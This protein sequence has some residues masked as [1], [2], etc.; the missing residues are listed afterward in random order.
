MTAPLAPLHTAH[1]FEP[2]HDALIQLLRGL[3]DD[4]WIR[5]TVAGQWRVRDVAAHLL[6][7]Q[8]RTLSALRDGHFAPPDGPLEGYDDLVR[9]LDRLNAGWIEASQRLSPRVIIELL[10]AVGPE[11]A[12]TFSALPPHGPALFPVA[13]AGEDTSENWMHVG[14]EYTE[15]WHHQMQIRDAVGAPGLFEPEWFQPL[16]DLSVRVLPHAYCDVE[17]KPG[18]SL[19]LEVDGPGGGTWSLVRDD[20]TWAMHAGASPTPDATI[21]LDPDTAWKTLYHA[22]DPNQAR[23]RARIEGEASLAA[24]FFRARSAMVPKVSKDVE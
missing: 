19:V 15:W 3:T 14:R 16:L 22:L 7:G 5:P 21:V 23:A 6:D 4:D 11:V 2:L 8:L 10:A 20:A 24:P 12:A 1:L 17:A 9:F 13:W 18:T